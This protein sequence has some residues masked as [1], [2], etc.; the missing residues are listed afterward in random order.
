MAP[1]AVLA[2]VAVAG[3]EECVGDLA[4]EA[5]GDVHELH[6]PDDGRFRKGQ[7]FAADEGIGV[8]FDD[9]GLAL[10]DETEGPAHRDHRQRLKGGIQRQAPHAYSPARTVAIKG[11]CTNPV[12]LAP[13]R[14]G[15]TG[16]MAGR[17]APGHRTVQA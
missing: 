16:A 6:Q 5:A 12:S 4:T 10:D 13:T 3:E 14:A 7:P 1:M 11:G 9:L 15:R 2:A 8:R 17:R